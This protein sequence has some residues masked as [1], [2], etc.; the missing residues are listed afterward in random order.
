MKK[1]AQGCIFITPIKGT[2]FSGPGDWKVDRFVLSVLSVP[3]DVLLVVLICIRGH[4]TDILTCW[5][6][7]I[8]PF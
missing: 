7:M 8:V 6:N 4:P 5:D 2:A 3:T 1:R